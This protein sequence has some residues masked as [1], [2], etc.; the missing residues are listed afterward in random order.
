MI[1]Y[2]YNKEVIPTVILAPRIS[3]DMSSYITKVA[4]FMFKFED[5]TQK[6]PLL[7]VTNIHQ[8]EQLLDIS[9][10]CGCK[11][12]KKYIDFKQQEIDVENGLAPN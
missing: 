7:I 11:P 8:E 9:R 5:E 12:I 4:E 1:P 3:R 10:L 2:Q 6:P